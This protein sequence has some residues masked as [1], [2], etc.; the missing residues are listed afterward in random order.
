MPT[1]TKAQQFTYMNA[2]LTKMGKAMSN[3]LPS[4]CRNFQCLNDGTTYQPIF[5]KQS[6]IFV[7]PAALT[8][9]KNVEVI[10]N[11]TKKYK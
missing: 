8:V 5:N 2:K 10:G 6:K 3:T 7:V 1:K 11:A 9:K 4:D